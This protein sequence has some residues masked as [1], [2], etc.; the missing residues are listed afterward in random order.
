MDNKCHMQFFCWFFFFHRQQSTAVKPIPNTACIMF[1]KSHIIHV[2]VCAHVYNL[3]YW[4][5]RTA[6]VGLH[7]IFLFFNLQGG[8]LSVTVNVSQDKITCSAR[9]NQPPASC[10]NKLC[11]PVIFSMTLLAFYCWLESFFFWSLFQCQRS[12]LLNSPCCWVIREFN[13]LILECLLGR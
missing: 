5:D 2:C 8:W 12:L 11:S 10:L 13:V 7:L 4:G 6:F 3:I 9:I 1:E